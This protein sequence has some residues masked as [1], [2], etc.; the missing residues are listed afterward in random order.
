MDDRTTPRSLQPLALVALLGLVV[1]F[2][3]ANRWALDNG[4]AP[5]W[6]QQHPAYTWFGGWKMFTELDKD[7]NIVTQCKSGMRSAKAQAFLRTQGFKRVRN[8]TGG[9]LGYI[10]QVDP[11]QPKY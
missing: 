2:L 7:A 11:S 4:D 5:R 9:I 6:I 10:D 8:L 1:Y 3:T